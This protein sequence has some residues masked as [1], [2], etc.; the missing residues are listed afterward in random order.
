MK[1]FSEIRGHTLRSSY[2]E[3]KGEFVNIPI[4]HSFDKAAPSQRAFLP[5]V[6]LWPYVE[7]KR[8]QR[9]LPALKKVKQ[10]V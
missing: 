1:G 5:S 3:K 2:D 7:L 4:A 8:E 9:A 6:Y 10:R